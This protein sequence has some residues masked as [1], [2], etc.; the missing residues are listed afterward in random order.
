VELE[1][2]FKTRS[3]LDEMAISVKNIIFASFPRITAEEREDI[4]QEVK[5]K[6]WRKI[7]RGKKVD[8]LRSYLW[9]VV[10]TT[11]LDVVQERI[12]GASRMEMVQQIDA[13]SASRLESLSPE[14]LVE[15]R[16][17][18]EIMKR[19]IDLLQP[20]RKTVVQLYLTGMNLEEI[21]D[22]LKWRGNQVRHLLYRGIQDLVATV[23]QKARKGGSK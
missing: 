10:Y 8:N 13:L 12:R 18:A 14:I 16:E 20:R 9:K 19:E 7:C 6:L 11:A 22:F 23:N 2:L 17:L 15:K 5:L 3:A 21:A 1:K 4:E